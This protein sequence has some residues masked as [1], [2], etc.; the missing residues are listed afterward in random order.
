MIP[1]PPDG[2]GALDAL[3][4]TT[5]RAGAR[6]LRCRAETGKPVAAHLAQIG[7]LGW[8]IILPM[9]AGVFAGAWLDRRLHSGLFYTA[10]LLMLGAGLGCWWGWRWMAKK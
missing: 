1:P 4:R 10:P 6:E 5:S 8:M 7:V 9:L 3:S 2:P